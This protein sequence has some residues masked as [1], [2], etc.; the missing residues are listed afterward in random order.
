MVSKRTSQPQVVR[1]LWYLRILQ[2]TASEI[3]LTKRP[4][5][6]FHAFDQ[7]LILIPQA[8]FS[9]SIPS[10]ESLWRNG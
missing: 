10:R 6:M 1:E 3:A 8:T 4:H 5:L 9:V 7:D 2:P